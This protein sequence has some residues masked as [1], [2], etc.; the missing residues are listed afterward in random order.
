MAKEIRIKPCEVFLFL[1]ACDFLHAVN[2]IMW[3][4]R[5]YFPYEGRCVVDF[6]A[7]PLLLDNNA[8]RSAI[9]RYS[10]LYNLAVFYL[11]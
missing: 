9:H 4:V 1:L 3:G 7:Q 11:F 8:R 10:C 2:L 5:P 6:L